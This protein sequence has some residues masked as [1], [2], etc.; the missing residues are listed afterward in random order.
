MS[1]P[2]YKWQHLPKPVRS[3]ANLRGRKIH[4]SLCIYCA[5]VLKLSVA[6]TAPKAF[7]ISGST[8]KTRSLSFPPL[9]LHRCPSWANQIQSGPLQ[10]IA[11]CGTGSQERKVRLMP[12]SRTASVSGCSATRLFAA[13]FGLR[14][15]DRPTGKA[16]KA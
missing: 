12:E 10:Q 6:R 16:S 7:M 5:S 11:A 15:A 8:C 13:R 2:P 9:E 3:N 14:T 1:Q 4:T